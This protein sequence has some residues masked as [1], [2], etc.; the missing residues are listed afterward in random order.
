[1]IDPR[2]DGVSE[3]DSPAT[4]GGANQGRGAEDRRPLLRVRGLKTYFRTGGRWFGET[5]WLRAVDGVDLDIARGEVLGVVGESGSGKTTLGRS[6]LGLVEPVEGTIRFDGTDLT[7]LNR[8][9]MR[10]LRRR[11]QVIFQD[12]HAAL[13]PRMQVQQLVG[14]PLLFHGIVPE[15]ELEVRVTELLRK[16]GLGPTFLRR[17]PHQMSGGQLQRVSIARALAPE[18]ELLVA[19]EPVSGLDVSVQA[20]ILGMMS[21]LQDREGIAMLFIAHDL[22]VVERV[23]DRVAVMY[24]GQ[25]VERAPVG[26]LIG[27]PLHPYT[28]A[29]L[30][31]VPGAGGRRVRLKGEAPS[32]TE[33]IAGCPF[34]S[35]CPEA[36][37]HCRRDPP[38]PL[39]E[40]A[41]G[42][43]AACH[44][45]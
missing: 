11:I 45:R 34:A 18:P 13:N 40:K 37:E 36:R 7:V 4:N 41:P 21:R 29:L 25:I 39:E 10:R 20:D 27:E 44:Y 38:P 19:D 16:V 32:Q 6:I 43:F 31:A 33:E 2:G 24:L 17:Y 5:E 23:A 8:K 22:P 42:H 12:P 26:R 35:R 9:E 15:E 28:Q 1:M 14:E 3:S 30:S